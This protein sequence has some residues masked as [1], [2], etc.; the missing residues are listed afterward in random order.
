MIRAM[1]GLLLALFLPVVSAAPGRN[2]S[3][4]FETFSLPLAEAAALLREK[5]RD[6][7]LHA[8]LVAGLAD[9]S[10]RQEGLTV[11]RTLEKSSGAS[12]AAVLEV[13]SPSEYIAI[14]RPG[15]GSGPPQPGE[16]PSSLIPVFGERFETHQF[17][18]ELSL[19]ATSEPAD[20]LSLRIQPRWTRQ[21]GRSF[22]GQGTALL[23]MPEIETQ[24][25]EATIQ[26]KAGKPSL[27]GTFNRI[28]ESKIAP[29]A[30]TRVW[31]AFI[32]VNPMES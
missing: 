2:L 5:P 14:W 13:R 3:V 29:L 27:L 19:E 4:V 31:F 28:P 32:T 15:T 21:A 26:V 7:E 6:A 30:P 12:T 11:L 22:H 23:A 1:T 25:M 16:F 17:G 18:F 20:P 9:P 8:R 10:V 24:R